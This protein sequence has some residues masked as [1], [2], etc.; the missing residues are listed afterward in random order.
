MPNAPKPAVQT[1]EQRTTP[2]GAKQNLRFDPMYN[3]AQAYGQMG[4]AAVRLAGTLAQA[5]DKYDNLKMQNYEEQINVLYKEMN[6]RLAASQNPA[7][8]DS[9]VNESM[10]QMRNTGKEYLGD[11]LFKQWE[12]QRGNNYYAALRADVTGQKIGLMQKLSFQNAQDTVEQKAYDYGYA[13]KEEQGI[14]DAQFAEYLQTNGFTP[15]QQQVLKKQYD[16]QKTNAYLERLLDTDPRQIAYL[17]KNGKVISPMDQKDQ[18]SNLTIKE[19]IDWKNKALRMQKAQR[20]AAEKGL[21]QAE[22]NQY[23]INKVKVLTRLDVLK[24]QLGQDE[25]LN[26]YKLFSYL[27]QVNDFLTRPE[28]GYKRADGSVA[29]YL[30]P[31]EAYSYQKDVAKYW[32]EALETINDQ[33]DDTYFSYGLKA[34]NTFFK[35]NKAFNGLNDFDKM[36]IVQEYYRQM[37]ASMP[38]DIMQSK[39]DI[40]YQGN[41]VRAAQNAIKSFTAR[42]KKFSQYAKNLILTVP[43]NIKTVSI[44]DEIQKQGPRNYYGMGDKY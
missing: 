7:E 14:L 18:Y 12:G 21:L 9:I 1:L 10:E 42:S 29:Y 8:Y 33:P 40:G 37:A 27:Q 23:A 38:A 13:P 5:Q 44:A 11:K 17:D 2:Q 16:S 31:S 4:E 24:E 39:A 26:P 41:T 34:I 28:T 19:K 36:D 15:A 25:K 32:N 35:Q 3:P 6:N 30:E 20:D 22:A 43:E